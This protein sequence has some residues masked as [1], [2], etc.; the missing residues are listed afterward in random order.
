MS[1][2]LVC[3]RMLFSHLSVISM[4]IVNVYSYHTEFTWQLSAAPHC[5]YSAPTVFIVTCLPF[6]SFRKI[7]KT[8]CFTNMAMSFVTLPLLLCIFV[9]FIFSSDYF[10]SIFLIL[11]PIA[12][13]PDSFV[14]Q[15]E[16]CVASSIF[17]AR[18]NR[19]ESSLGHRFLWVRF[20][21]VFYFPPDK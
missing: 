5:N 9:S 15:T 21:V 17:N 11:F 3:L 7:W 13:I 16:W 12:L 18:G 10:S 8:L 14:D 1:L 6:L 20:Y 2:D 19:F 4:L